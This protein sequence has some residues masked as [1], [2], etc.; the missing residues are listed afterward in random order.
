MSSRRGTAI[1]C[2]RV[3]DAEVIIVTSVGTGTVFILDSAE[4]DSTNQ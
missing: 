1:T 4:L 3:I 2:N